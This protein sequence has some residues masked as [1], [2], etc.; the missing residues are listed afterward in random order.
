VSAAPAASDGTMRSVLAALAANTAIATAKGIA[1]A[2]T[3]SSALV[4]ETLHTVADAGNEVFL[5]IAVRRSERP[6]DPTHPLGYA[7][8]RYYWALLAALGMFV[9][10]GAVSI[11]EGI[12]ALIHPPEIVSFWI[13]AGVLVIAILL[14]GTSRIIAQ[15]TLR[16][17]AR[18][19]QT[20]VRDLLR[21]SPDPTVT[22]VYLEDTVDVLGATLALLALILHQLTGSDL[23]DAIATLAIGSLLTFVAVRLA[24]RNRR[25]LSNQALP[26]DLLE[27][28]RERIVS[29]PGVGDVRRL[30]AVYLGPTDVLVAAEVLVLDGMSAHELAGALD[31]AADR[32]RADV[33]ALTRI[34][35]TPV[36]DPEPPDQPA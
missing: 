5:F 2:I 4:A 33:P 25:L 13:G 16:E 28:L 24:S 34:Y 3:G 9:I 36:A 18:R 32:I 31:R 14:D 19:R 21:E 6:A 17:Q 1:A 26:D 23:P 10:G 20:T 27:R 7:P 30:E 35:L 22:T 12:N 8:E 15:H 11:W 29:Q